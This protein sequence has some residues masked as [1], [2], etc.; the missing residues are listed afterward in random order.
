MDYTILCLRDRPEMLE[1]AAAWFHA[2]WGIPA[3]AYR[4][5]MRQCLAGDGPVPQWYMALAGDQIAGGLG[6]IEN[7]FHDRK[8]LTPNVCAVYVEEAFRRRG[9][10]GRLLEHVRRDMGRLGVET[11]YLLTDHT[12]LYE[13]WG[14]TFFCI[15]QG[16][17]E[18]APSRVYM[19]GT[20]EEGAL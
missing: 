2:K 1:A 9:I 10:A 6:V 17:G 13:R 16:G 20:A 11:L 18:P 19:R 14:W 3:E 4:D 7:D 8:D 5:S 15:A 12:A